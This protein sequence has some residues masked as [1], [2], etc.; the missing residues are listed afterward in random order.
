MSAGLKTWVG[1]ANLIVILIATVG[2]GMVFLSNMAD[3]A[4]VGGAAEEAINEGITG[5][6]EY[7]GW[8]GLVILL[9]VFVYFMGG[10]KNFGKN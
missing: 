9:G 3:N 10:F 7:M 6:G 5:M 8:I 2:F 4:S 1:N